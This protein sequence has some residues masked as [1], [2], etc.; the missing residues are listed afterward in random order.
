MCAWRLQPFM[1]FMDL[2][3]SFS[4]AQDHCIAGFLARSSALWMGG[5]Q[6]PQMCICIC[7]CIWFCYTATLRITTVRVPLHICPLHAFL[8]M[9]L[10]HMHAG[11]DAASPRAAPTHA[12]RLAATGREHVPAH[13]C[14]H[15]MAGPTGACHRWRLHWH[16]ACCS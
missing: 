11:R 4:C 1:T 14:A 13:Q 5:A 2:C 15:H 7:I 16:A 12:S 10:A 3:M 6:Q 9:H 8:A